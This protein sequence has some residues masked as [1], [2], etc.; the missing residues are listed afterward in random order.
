MIKEIEKSFGESCDSCKSLSLVVVISR[1]NSNSV[2]EVC[3]LYIA[4]I[5]FRLDISITKDHN[6]MTIIVEF[7]LQF[8]NVYFGNSILLFKIRKVILW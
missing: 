8:G 5:T 2:L 6:I 3:V 4:I 7:W 1:S